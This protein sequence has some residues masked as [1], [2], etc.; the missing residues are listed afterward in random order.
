MKGEE[1]VWRWAQES[2]PP[3]VIGAWAV[4]GVVVALFIVRFRK[5]WRE[6]VKAGVP[7]AVASVAL[8]CFICWAR[9]DTTVHYYERV[10]DVLRDGEGLRGKRLKV[11]GYVTCG[12]VHQVIGTD[13]YRFTIQ[14]LPSQSDLR[15]EVRYT[16]LLPDTFVA[17]KEVV[18]SG[19]LAADAVLDAIPDG[20]MAK[21]GNRL[22]LAC[23]EGR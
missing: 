9:Q 17:G 3:V 18:V 14:H 19:R 13:D 7:L 4:V 2:V 21:C 12:S 15:L 16:G 20:I 11:H 22:P 10:G 23:D 8:G 1:A 6:G 5:D